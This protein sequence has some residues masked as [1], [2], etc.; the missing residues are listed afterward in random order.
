MRVVVFI[1]N[2]H[3]SGRKSSSN[4]SSWNAEFLFTVRESWETLW[5]Y[6]LSVLTEHCHQFYIFYFW[7]YSIFIY[8]HLFMSFKPPI[9]TWHPTKEQISHMKCQKTCFSFFSQ[10]N[11][12][13]ATA[14]HT[15]QFAVETNTIACHAVALVCKQELVCVVCVRWSVLRR[16]APCQ[17]TFTRVYT[18]VPLWADG[19]VFGTTNN[20]RPDFLL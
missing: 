4:D 5:L 9:H 16:S 18:D 2:S 20:A 7:K 13:S 11:Q 17:Q 15:E 19:C 6:L 10:I 3:H 8:E 12:T 14:E 1:V